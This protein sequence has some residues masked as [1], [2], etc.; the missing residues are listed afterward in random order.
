MNLVIYLLYLLESFIFDNLSRAKIEIVFCLIFISLTPTLYALQYFLS[1]DILALKLFYN[2]ISIII[3][4]KLYIKC[5]KL[6]FVMYLMYNLTL[7]SHVFI[8]L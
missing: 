6:R 8:S 1:N 2:I 3:Q 4:D 5:F 7:E